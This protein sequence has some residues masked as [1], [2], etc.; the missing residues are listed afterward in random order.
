V[1]RAAIAV[2]A[3]A[4][5]G[6]ELIV[7]IGDTS[8]APDIQPVTV[9]TGVHGPLVVASTV[10]TD[11][12]R[13]NLSRDVGAGSTLLHVDTS[14]GFEIGDE[15]LIIQM[16][17][18]DAGKSETGTVVASTAATLR[19]DR[20]IKNTFNID[21]V[22]QVIRVMNYTDVTV[23]DGARLTAH[24]WDGINGGVV[25]FRA[26]GTV[27]VA[28]G[29]TIDAIGGAGG[30]AG[31]PAPATAGG[32]KG[33]GGPRVNCPLTGCGSVTQA[34]FGTAGE[35]GP[36]Q[37][38]EPGQKANMCAAG[39]GGR[40]GEAG[41]A[42]K[43]PGAYGAGTGPGGALASS[44]GGAYLSTSSTRPMIGGGGA[45][46][47]GALG[48]R[49][50]G[51]GGGGGGALSGSNNTQGEGGQNGTDGEA[52][53]LAGESGAGGNGGGIVWINASAIEIDGAISA[54]G[55]AGGIATNGLD[56]GKGGDGG[57]GGNAYVQCANT[58]LHGGDGGAGF[59]AGGGG[60]GNGGGGG[61]GGTVVIEAFS[62][63]AGGMMT[64]RGGAGTDATT[65]GMGGPGG[66]GFGG[67]APSGDA[68]MP[69]MAGRIGDDG[70]IYIFYVDACTS[71]EGIGEPV[72][73]VMAR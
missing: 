10:Y 13:T 38:G 6:C 16:T 31:T 24:P 20:G 26:S 5:G 42:V 46:G 14:D 72:A 28:S 54:S 17:N 25:F 2:V 35:F 39:S 40:G 15:V 65:A 23:P 48:G 27:R 52:G 56:G 8:L 1:V 64:A 33:F 9:G 66:M 22:T 12:V 43:S 18:E 47:A 21:D 4:C 30:I 63:R 57:A 36:G 61:A 11:E 55:A 53:G 70:R 49:G 68:G 69:G 71:C 37:L 32:L 7:G 44:G 67:Q 73:S 59:G 60:G 3:L 41:G 62:V 19:L 50:A 51:G 45:G 29:G 58:S 34:G